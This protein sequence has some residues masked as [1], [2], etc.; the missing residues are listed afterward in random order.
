MSAVFLFYQNSP[1]CVT[2][3][4]Y[5]VRRKEKN[6]TLLVQGCGYAKLVAVKIATGPNY[7]A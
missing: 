4:E 3:F 1:S 7:F 2:T 5:S 6:Y